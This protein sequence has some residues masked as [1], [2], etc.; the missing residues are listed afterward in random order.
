M[1]NDTPKEGVVIDVTPEPE[2]AATSS[3]KAEAAPPEK[4]GRSG[5]G[6]P[7]LALLFGLAAIVL[8]LAAGWFG[9]RQLRDIDARLAATS[10]QG[11]AAVSEARSLAD[12]VSRIDGTQQSLAGRLDALQSGQQ[13]AAGRLDGIEQ[14][15]DQQAQLLSSERRLLDERETEL[16][17]L[18]ANL[19]ERVGRSG[20]Q[21]LVAEAGYLLNLADHRLRL[22]GDPATA[23]AALALADQRLH[24]TG[25][26]GWAGVREQIARDLTALDTLP[27]PDI[28]GLWAR[29]GALQ[30]QVA[31]L[32]LREGARG[33]QR[34]PAPGVVLTP[35][36]EER[37]WRTLL[38][39]LWA[40]IKNAVRIRR[41]D[42]PV[43][44]MLPPE[45]EYFLYENL[46]LRLE[47]ARL[48]LVQGRAEIYRQALT[49]SREWLASHFDG[50]DPVTRGLDAALAELVDTPIRAELPDI[51]TSLSAFQARRELLKALPSAPATPEA[52][53]AT[54]STEAPAA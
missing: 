50:S 8:T 34:G 25:D 6:L 54:E 27:R 26:P 38:S 17:T 36:A 48:A 35:A 23:R 18:V 15:F 31:N 14:A 28:T 7:L 20:T 32:K 42:E 49:E 16:R 40:G 29:L 3:Q 45:Q 44:A 47:Q 9:Y 4:T 22:A 10:S 53:P 33:V 19:H 21:W 1:S 43:A 11:G 46:R 12:Q 30:G 37:S 24:A 51:S 13:A 2:E 41:H 52:A 5:R 39:D